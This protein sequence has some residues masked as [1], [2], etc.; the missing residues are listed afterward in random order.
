MST[1]RR[2][3][4]ETLLI[5]SGAGITALSIS[6]DAP[7]WIALGLLA[8][9]T[10]ASLWGVWIE[11]SHWGAILASWRREATALARRAGVDAPEGVEGERALA[12]VSAAGDALE[13]RAERE[14]EHARL[15]RTIVDAFD[16]PVI[17]TDEDGVVRTHNTSAQAFVASRAAS[18]VGRRIDEV[19]TWGDV[20]RVHASARAGREAHE[21]VRAARPGAAG[22]AIATV[23]VWARPLTGPGPEERLV[24]LLMRDVS[25]ASRTLQVRA[26]FVANASHELRTP[27]AAMRVAIDT[28]RALD[29]GDATSRDRFLGVV[30]SNIE[31]LEELIADLL[32]LSRLESP[33]S[34][35]QVGPVALARLVETLEPLFERARRERRLQVA[36]DLSPRVDPVRTDRRLLLLILQNLIDNAMKFAYEDTTVRVVATPIPAGVR[37]EVVDRGIGIPLG[38]QQRIFERFYQVDAARTGVGAA[39]RG[40]GLG[41]AI[42]RHAVKRLGGSVRVESVW[43]EGTRMIV[44]LPELPENHSPVASPA[45]GDTPRP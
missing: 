45:A 20:L 5:A 39:R 35:L 26:D 13:A 15:L 37:W 36:W 19:I 32:D 7:R 42:V 18:L 14:R 17:L 24:L 28:L 8:L 34:E 27:I 33:E 1:D 4:P 23:D 10:I 44:E 30:S 11:R 40:T 21:Q 9:A 41:L 16:E 25:E 31:R 6:L 43:K 2:V 3:L 38:Q 12:L 29:G 22:G